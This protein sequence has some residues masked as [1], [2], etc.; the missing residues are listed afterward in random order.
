VEEL[1]AAFKQHPKALILCNPSNPCGKVFSRW[2]VSGSQ[3]KVQPRDTGSA[4][5]DGNREESGD[6]L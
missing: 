5:K 2:S 6:R 4:V 1:E 3:Q